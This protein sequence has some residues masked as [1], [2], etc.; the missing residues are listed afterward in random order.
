MRHQV[1]LFLEPRAHGFNMSRNE[2]LDSSVMSGYGCPACDWTVGGSA[3][4][5]NK[6]KNMGK[7]IMFVA[8]V[9]QNNEKPYQL[10]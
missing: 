5:I 9:D 7:F 4:Q 8:N 10:N 6:I 3:W 2:K 1:P